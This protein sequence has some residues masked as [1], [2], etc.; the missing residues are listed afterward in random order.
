MSDYQIK[1]SGKQAIV[2]VLI[3]MSLWA[4]I[5]VVSKLGQQNLDN[6]QFL[7][8]SSLVSFVVLFITTIATKNHAHLK[9]YSPREWLTAITLGFLGTYAYYILL[10]FAYA[11][12]RGLEVLVLQY[13]W[14]IF[15]VVLSVILLKE[16]LN[17]VKI[18]S[19]ALGFLGVFLVISKGNFQNLH[20]ENISVDLLVI[21]GTA[22]FALFSVLSKKVELEPISV[23]TVYFLTATCL[24]FI[25][26][27]LLSSFSLPTADSI[28]PILLN[29]ILVNGFSYILWIIAL[30]KTQASFLAPFVFLTP[31]LSTVYL[32][33]F[34][35]EPFLPVYAI[36][37]VCVIVAGI[38]NR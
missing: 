38:M 33:L 27:I 22:S 8:W 36:G 6:H 2:I 18:I 15:I 5:P 12:A 21:I 29:G 32:I 24:S 31:V 3:F 10:Y 14:P 26:M 19:L 30:K 7:F 1:K 9:K 11:N 16:R 20:F 28:I 37:L 23:T 17:T 25:S 34:F 13:S 35:N 4:L